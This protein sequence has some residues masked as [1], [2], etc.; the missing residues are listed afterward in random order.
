M[1]LGGY[2]GELVSL[3]KNSHVHSR[4]KFPCSPVMKGVRCVVV[5]D[6]TRLLTI[7]GK[8]RSRVAEGLRVRPTARELGSVTLRTCKSSFSP[9][10]E[11]GCKLG[12]NRL[13]L[14]DSDKMLLNQ[15]IKKSSKEHQS[16][17]SAFTH[18]KGH[19][20]R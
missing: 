4:Q 5:L 9:S 6:T 7:T 18:I 16:D 3:W 20:N 13:I 14:V 1:E 11:S 10:G 17:L 15:S 8:S 2:L 12:N 19:N